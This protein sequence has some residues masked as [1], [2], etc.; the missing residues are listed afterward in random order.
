MVSPLK[1]SDSFGPDRDRPGRPRL[2]TEL[3]S[4]S[5]RDRLLAGALQAVSEYGYPA[6]TVAQIIAA[7]GISRKTFYDIFANKEECILVAYDLLV[8]WL[9]DRIAAAIAGIESWPQAV[10]VAVSE[11]LACLAADP[12]I[13]CLC[14]AEILRV[15]RVGFAR[16][17][18]SIERLAAPLRSGRAQARWGAQLPPALEQT[19]VGGAL[20]L[21]GNRAR[22]D[23]PRLSELAPD[24]TYF[25]LVP[26]LGTPQARSWGAG[27]INAVANS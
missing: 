24:I 9:G 21:V 15:D 27:G 2:F 19:I 4:Q 23:Y 26:Y 17:Q 5:Q 10:R 7:A 8:D 20:W 18:A 25:L 16:Y 1:T 22:L 12:Q 3:F 13:A 14:T 11:T 6:T